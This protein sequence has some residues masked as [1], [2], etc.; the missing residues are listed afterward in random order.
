MIFQFEKFEYENMR[1]E[2]KSDTKQRLN[3][4]LCKEIKHIFK[5]C[6][7]PRITSS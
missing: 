5:P 3:K 2:L 7:Q 4:S 1:G 6:F